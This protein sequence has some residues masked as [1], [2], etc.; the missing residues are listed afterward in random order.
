MFFC[1]CFWSMWDLAKIEKY[2]HQTSRSCGICSHHHFASRLFWRGIRSWL[3]PMPWRWSVF[4][5]RRI[6]PGGTL[7]L[8]W[9]LGHVRPVTTMTDHEQNQIIA[10][11]WLGMNRL[12]DRHFNSLVVLPTSCSWS[13]DMCMYMY[14]QFGCILICI[15]EWPH[16]L[17]KYQPSEQHYLHYDSASHTA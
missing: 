15:Y 16:G 9:P 8:P 4:G 14:T 2:R 6:E 3:P 17:H 7:A 13:M 10:N 11:N 12:R 5:T 1:C